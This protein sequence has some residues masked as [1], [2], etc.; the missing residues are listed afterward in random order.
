M[1]ARSPIAAG[2]LALALGCGART[3]LLGAR[4]SAIGDGAIGAD[5]S[6]ELDRCPSALLAGAP[7]AIAGS[8]STRDG[9]SRVAGPT[10]PH[11]LWR[12][13]VPSPADPAAFT[14]VVTLASDASGNAYALLKPS[15]DNAGLDRLLRL[16]GATGAVRWDTQFVP[17]QGISATPTILV[18]GEID[19]VA[20]QFDPVPSLARFDAISGMLSTTPFSNGIVGR[21]PSPAVGA[22]GASYYA[23]LTTVE[24]LGGLVVSRLR[25]DT[26]VDWTSI[27]FASLGAPSGGSPGAYA[28]SSI[29]LGDNDLVLLAA[30]V[31]GSA[32][33]DTTRLLALDPTDGSLRWSAVI[34][35]ELKAGPIVASDGSIVVLSMD[36]S[37]TPQLT[38]Y[39][40]TGA[41]RHTVEPGTGISALYA[42]A[43]DGTVSRRDRTRAR[44]S[45]SRRE[46]RA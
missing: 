13:S 45:L 10:A 18:D 17:V 9:R 24:P 43:A 44:L 27:D 38:V 2:L 21:D 19:V 35:G 16:D 39:E 31:Y 6:L 41:V 23:Y 14:Q 22:D 46:K 33:S 5:A 20:S 32:S 28:L 8:C 37:T 1:H 4:N 7:R 12:S 30:Y 36:T 26:T 29:A 3:E 34:G 25:P 15:S 40:P 42:I 11:V